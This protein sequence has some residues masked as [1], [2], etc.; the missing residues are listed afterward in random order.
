MTPL[1]TTSTMH[2]SDDSE[3]ELLVKYRTVSV[4]A[5]LGLVLGGLS[6][7][8]LLG[9]TLWMFPLAGLLLNWRAL[10]GLALARGAQAGRGIAS[11][12]LFLS[13]MFGVAGPVEFWGSRWL[14]EQSAAP[15][16]ETWISALRHKQPERALQLTLTAMLRQP[17]SADLSRY[18]LTHK[19][20]HDRLQ[21]YVADP[22]V[23]TLLLL[24]ERAEVR[25]YD[26]SP[27]VVEEHRD[28]LARVYAVT[29]D[30]QGT[31]T[32]FFISMTLERMLDK[33]QQALWRIINVTG[34]IHP[35]SWL[36]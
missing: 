11:L 35:P 5:V 16:A 4:L 15:A 9:P 20:A 30:D 17:A 33:S 29:F 24:G 32:T 6:G 7:L 25:L 28:L 21:E 23:K 31:K 22:V 1:S 36:D 34:G 3:D 26:T 8:A 27:P 10:H 2:V 19:D 18:Y 14:L 12:G 13:V